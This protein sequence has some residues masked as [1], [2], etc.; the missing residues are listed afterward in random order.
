MA[1]KYTSYNNTLKYALF[2]HCGQ[3]GEKETDIKK[4][5]EQ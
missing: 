3:L 2:P 4:R 5:W 1:K